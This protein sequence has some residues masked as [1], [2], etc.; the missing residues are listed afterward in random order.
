MPA[1]HYTLVF[2]EHINSFLKCLLFS[3]TKTFSPDDESSKL[4]KNNR[5]INNIK[6]IFLFVLSLLFILYIYIYIYKV[7][8]KESFAEFV[9]N[10]FKIYVLIYIHVLII[11]FFLFQVSTKAMKINDDQVTSGF[12][13]TFKK[14]HIIPFFFFFC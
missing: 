6:V 13:L 5:K 3:P 9:Y 2:I 1:V 8:Y 7:E 10:V 12:R 11:Y 4:V 14:T